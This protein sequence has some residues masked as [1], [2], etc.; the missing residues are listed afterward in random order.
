MLTA[1]ALIPLMIAIG[2]FATFLSRAAAATS[3]Q[4]SDTR[5]LCAITPR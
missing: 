4:S 5:P 2:E 1:V 3:T